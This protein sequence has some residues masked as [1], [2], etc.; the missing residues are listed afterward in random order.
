MV[1]ALHCAVSPGEME[2]SCDGDITDGPMQDSSLFSPVLSDLFRMR[3][4]SESCP[5]LSNPALSQVSGATRLGAC[6]ASP[7]VLTQRSSP[8]M[9]WLSDWS[10]SPVLD[11]HS[12]LP[13]KATEMFSSL[14]LHSVPCPRCAVETLSLERA[15]CSKT[16]PCWN[17]FLTSLLPP[18]ATFLL[19]I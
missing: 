12:T 19:F 9:M 1:T 2:T 18:E 13:A 3:P 17:S 14:S 11:C 10:M 8:C 5:P 4:L 16:T 7:H 15:L 6:Y